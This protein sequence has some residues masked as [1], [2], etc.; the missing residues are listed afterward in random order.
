VAVIIMNRFVIKPVLPPPTKLYQLVGAPSNAPDHQYNWQKGGGLPS[1]GDQYRFLLDRTNSV[2][3]VGLD[4]VPAVLCD[5]CDRRFE[6]G[7]RS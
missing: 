7:A 6:F 2:Q 4:H 1:A 3:M 5:L